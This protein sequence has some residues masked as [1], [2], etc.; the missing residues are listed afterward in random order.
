M[1]ARVLMRGLDWGQERVRFIQ[2]RANSIIW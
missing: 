1:K 2:Q